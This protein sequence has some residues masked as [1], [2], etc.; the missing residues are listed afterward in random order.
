MVV[1]EVGIGWICGEWGRIHLGWLEQVL[2]PIL[3]IGGIAL[4]IWSVL[5]QSTI[6]NGT[7][8]PMVATQKA[9]NAGTVFL[10][11]QPDDTWRIVFI[12]RNRYLDEFWCT[13][14]PKHDHF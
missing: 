6:G 3:T 1:L 14:H 2:G 12:L 7:P 8:A 5:T 4:V 11:A 10:Y 13:H 9:C